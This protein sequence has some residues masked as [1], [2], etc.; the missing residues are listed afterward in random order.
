LSCTSPSN[1][2]ASPRSRSS[3]VKGPEP[4]STAPQSAASGVASAN[5]KAPRAMERLILGAGYFRCGNNA[6]ARVPTVLAHPIRVT[7]SSRPRKSHSIDPL[8]PCERRRS[9]DRSSTSEHE[10]QST[11]CSKSTRRPKARRSNDNFDFDQPRTIVEPRRCD[12]ICMRHRFGVS[13]S[14][15]RHAPRGGGHEAQRDRAV[16]GQPTGQQQS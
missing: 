5:N 8:D 9:G 7:V 14:S 4:V 12:R 3:Q 16:G 13:T 11:G 15:E 6:K 2:M 1:T 10:S